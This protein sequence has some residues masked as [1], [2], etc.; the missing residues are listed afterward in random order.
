MKFSIQ[1][2]YIILL[3]F[4][5]SFQIFSQSGKIAGKITDGTTGEDMPFVNI[6]VMG[7]NYGAASDIEGSY[8][9]IGIPPGTYSLK[10]SAIGYN[11][12][13]V[14][15]I[16]VSID[17]TTK[18][19][20]QVRETSIELGEEVIVIATKPSV[21]KDLTSSTS[22]IG[23]EDILASGY[24]ISGNAPIKSRYCWWQCKRRQ[25]G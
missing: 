24:R 10:A 23:S 12:V 25:K 2:R 22:I 16:R 11:A 18:I 1:I 9:I 4:L 7:T 5:F 20:F 13:T 14:Q 3:S 15:D 17:L 6:I 8:S 21:T 19:D